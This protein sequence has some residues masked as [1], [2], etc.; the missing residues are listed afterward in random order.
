[1]KDIKKEN[2]ELKV[3]NAALK[4][5][6]NLLKQQ[7]CFLERMIMKTGG[8]QSYTNHPINNAET[9]FQECLLPLVN[10]SEE[11]STQNTLGYFRA[12]PPHTF[13]KHAMFL[14]MLT[15]L[16]C[17]SSFIGGGS[18]NGVQPFYPRT[19]DEFKNNYSMGLKNVDNDL[20]GNHQTDLEKSLSALLKANQEYNSWKSLVKLI[21]TTSYIIYFIYVLLIT[22]WKYLFRMKNK[23]LV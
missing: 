21:F 15:I 6:N 10:K 3:Q 8:H 17:A 12:A 5:E 16:I 2:A 4:A 22:N 13:K 9:N 11:K 23:K 1:M 20:A 19:L 7:T 18:D 14:G